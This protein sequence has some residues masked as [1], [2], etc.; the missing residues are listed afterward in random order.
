M[1]ALVA[2]E[3]FGFDPEQVYTE[4]HAICYNE[5]LQAATCLR[6][7]LIQVSLPSLQASAKW[8][9]WCTETVTHI[10]VKSLSP[11]HTGVP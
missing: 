11:F 9:N 5:F 7:T 8:V 1:D 3:F 2:G 6:N 4:V 10:E